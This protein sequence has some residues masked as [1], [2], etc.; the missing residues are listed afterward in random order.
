[1]H[2]THTRC[3]RALYKQK[4]NKEEFS[5]GIGLVSSVV[6]ARATLPIL[7]NILVESNGADEIRVVGTDLEIGISGV[8]MRQFYKVDVFKIKEHTLSLFSFNFSAPPEGISS[9]FYMHLFLV[10]VLLA[11]FPW[12]KLMHAGGVFFSAIS[13]GFLI[14]WATIGVST[15]IR[16]LLS[17][18]VGVLAL[19]LGHWVADLIWHWFLSYAV[20]KGKVYLN[21]RWYQN[22][23]RFLS[24]LLAVLG[25][26]AL[27]GPVGF[28]IGPI[29][30]TLLGEF[31]RIYQEMIVE[32]KNKELAQG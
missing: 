1:M 3:R 24:I 15:T 16:A 2:S 6:N 11:Y 18:V 10:C 4:T 7:S 28:I 13:P 30:V 21:D 31:I 17:G 14:W 5:K 26:I 19:M 12:S 29:I 8:L 25:G 27:F 22:I 9:L 20:D 23:I 32:G